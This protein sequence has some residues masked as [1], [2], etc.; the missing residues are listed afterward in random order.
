MS[1]KSNERLAVLKKRE[2]HLRNRIAAADAV[3]IDLSYDKAEAS[4]LRWAQAELAARGEAI[5]WHIMH[6]P[7]S[8]PGDAEIMATFRR[9]MEEGS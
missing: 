4:A 6:H 7:Q 9:V 5:R 8:W 1:T 3:G 2:N